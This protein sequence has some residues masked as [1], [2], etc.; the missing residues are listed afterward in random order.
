MGWLSKLRSKFARQTQ[1]VVMPAPVVQAHYESTRVTPDRSWLPGY[2]QDARQDIDSGTRIELMRRSRYFEKNSALA[3]K[4]LDLIETNVVG[5]GIMPTPASSDKAWNEA[6]LKWFLEW[7]KFADLTSKQNFWTLQAIMARAQAVDGEIFVFL[8]SG[9]SGR[10]RLQLIESHRVLSANLPTYKNEGY[11]D[12]DGVLLDQYGRPAFYVIGN[13]SD[14]LAKAGPSQV[15]VIPADQMVH[16]GEPARAGQYRCIPIFHA[17]LHTL[18][19]LDDLQRYEMLAAKE[20]ASQANVIETESG[21]VP[22][23]SGIVGR[24]LRVTKEDGTEETRTAYYQSAFGGKSVVLKRGDKWRQSESNRPSPAMRDFWQYLE[25]LTCKGVGISYAAVSDYAGNWGGAA[26]RG[27]VTSDNRFY[28]IRTSNLASA[29]QRIWEYVMGWAI[30]A[31]E[32]VDANGQPLA[33]PSDWYAVHWQPPRRASVDIGR[34]SAAIINEVRSGL[35]TYRD[36]LGELGLDWRD[37]LRQRAEEE[38]FIDELS[39]ETG[40]DR[41]RIAAFG[42]NE[43]GPSAGA[44]TA[45]PDTAPKPDPVHAS[46][47]A[48]PEPQ[49]VKVEINVQQTRPPLHLKRDANGEIS[50]LEYQKSE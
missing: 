2:V 50:V 35:R 36:V 34:E 49:K 13:D 45:S 25:A 8:T 40:V 16:V 44:P 11:I 29:S 22:D 14:A 43:R 20:A 9:H 15:A 23:E 3:Q 1:V 4:I 32:I 39:K 30:N 28:E 46:H 7:A 12:F 33:P 31:K 27:A 42:P 21:E 38:E 17:V 48:P 6:A 10:P 37:V 26:L 19:D 5:T 47:S 24:S 18:H 41:T